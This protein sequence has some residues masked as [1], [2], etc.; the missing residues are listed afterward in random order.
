MRPAKYAAPNA[1][2]SKQ[3]DADVID[4]LKY[5]DNLCHTLPELGNEEY[6][7]ITNK[8]FLRQ[9]AGEPIGLVI[10]DAI[11]EASAR[12]IKFVSY[13]SGHVDTI[14]VAIARAV[15][16]GINK[17]N[18]EIVLTRAGEMG[19]GHVLVSEHMG[20]RVTKEDNYTNH[21]WWQGQVY[22]LDWNNEILKKYDVY[23]PKEEKGFKWLRKMKEANKKTEIKVKFPD[24][25]RCDKF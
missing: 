2:V 11:K 1:V 15:R 10:K 23:V 4:S 12:G 14:E 3:V 6:I 19:A 17:A 25:V 13:D 18:A 22:K 9:R 5:V 20:A 21:A 24:F 8:A 7:D 16:S